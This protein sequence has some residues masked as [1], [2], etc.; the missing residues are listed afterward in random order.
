[1]YASEIWKNLLTKSST[2]RF[3]EYIEQSDHCQYSKLAA[4][5]QLRI[6]VSVKCAPGFFFMLDFVRK[7]FFSS[8]QASPYPPLI[9]PL[10]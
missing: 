8:A 1:M 7:F 6:L 10:T 9:A 2:K 4:M 5:V 3:P